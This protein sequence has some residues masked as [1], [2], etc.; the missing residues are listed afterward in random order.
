M[1][2]LLLL[3]SLLVYSG[4]CYTMSDHSDAESNYIS[5]NSD[6]SS[7]SP[8]K[9][10]ENL[11]CKLFCCIFEAL[12]LPCLETPLVEKC[13]ACCCCTGEKE[14]TNQPT[15][16]AIYPKASE[17]LAQPQNPSKFSLQA[18]CCFKKS[19]RKN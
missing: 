9:D 3:C 1:K 17:S 10:F 19:I 18:L 5:D 8:E 15:T 16:T 13:Y 4:Y 12:C 7:S 2:K 14:A 6:S 11:V